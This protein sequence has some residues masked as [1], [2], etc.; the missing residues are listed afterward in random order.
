VERMSVYGEDGLEKH[1]HSRANTTLSTDF[2][3]VVDAEEVGESKSF[4]VKTAN[5]C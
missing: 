5:E 3:A 4:A 2:D 1:V